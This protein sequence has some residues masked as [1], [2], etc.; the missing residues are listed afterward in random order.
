AY[1]LKADGQD[2]YRCNSPFRSGSDSM[3]FV[4]SVIDGHMV[5]CDHAD[6][7]RGYSQAQI[8][9]QLGLESDLALEGTKRPY[10]GIADYAAAHGLTVDQLQQAGWSETTYQSRPALA[11]TTRSGTR[12]RFL[13]GQ[14]P[15]YKSPSGYKSCW[16]KLE[17]ALKIARQ[18]RLLVLCNG[19]ISTVTGQYYGIAATSVT[20]GEKNV[21]AALVLELKQSLADMP[22]VQIVIALDCDAAGQKAAEQQYHTLKAAGLDVKAVDLRLGLGGDLADF[23]MLH[24]DTCGEAL[25]KLPLL[26]KPDDE[27]EFQFLKVS[28]L[29]ALPPIEWLVPRQITKRGLTVV[30]G[31]SGSYKSFFM[32]NH[33]LTLAQTD[34]VL[35]IAG[36]GV[37]GYQQRIRA[38]LMHHQLP[39]PE[40]HFRLIAGNVN[41]F[42]EGNIARFA[43]I[44]SQHKPV[45]IVID[46]LAM[47]S[48]NADENNTRDMNA[49][50]RGC[51]LLG[52][53]TQAAIVLVH[54]TGKEG[55]QERGSSALRGAADGMIRLEADDGVVRV[56]STKSKDC[57]GFKEFGLRPVVIAL[58]YQ[59]NLG[60]NVTSVV[61]VETSLERL[62]LS[63]RDLDVLE[64]IFVDPG[65]PLTAIAQELEISGGKGT[66]S[67]ILKRLRK[68]DLLKINGRDK[69]ITEKGQQ[70][71]AERDAQKLE[72]SPPV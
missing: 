34:P 40:D 66:V 57:E 9:A 3:A 27:Q 20:A 53:H 63:E 44:A 32:L 69:I 13:D 47:A 43:D 14:K 10:T 39:V 35:Y 50:I 62:E 22:D 37:E 31:R 28:D 17:D 71:L 26:V 45:M 55:R 41:L 29:F 18:T 72:A 56:E 6:G 59:N 51:K 65:I 11:I 24:G 70:W 1:G 60:E 8:A 48:G 23:C 64:M 54:H 21:P 2:R 25:A 38:W 12:Y 33:A 58:G 5:G 49:I 42:D 15:P 19:E 61:L 30:Y 16:Y 67:K 46:T 4:V 36:E 52:K 7:Q 68:H